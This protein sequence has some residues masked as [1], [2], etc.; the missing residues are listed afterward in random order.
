MLGRE[1]Q[2]P[3]SFLIWRKARKC[4]NAEVQTG[5]VGERRH[6]SQRGPE[7]T[8]AW[9]GDL[10]CFLLAVSGGLWFHP[11]IAMFSPGML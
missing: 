6:T 1:G 3:F 7:G 10:L 8:T 2:C 11:C 5:E 9:E 4:G